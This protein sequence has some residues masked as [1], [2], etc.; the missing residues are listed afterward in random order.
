MTAPERDALV[1]KCT[2]KLMEIE[3]RLLPCGLCD[4]QAT[5]GIR[6]DRHSGQI[7]SLDR[8]EE[9]ILSL[10]RII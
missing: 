5:D 4:W 3:S 2:S 1:G 7:T 6:G 10:P 8:S 9:E